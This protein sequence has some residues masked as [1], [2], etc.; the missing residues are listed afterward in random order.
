MRIGQPRLHM[1][2]MNELN[3][4]LQHSILTLAA[5]GWSNRRIARELGI[6]RETVSRH[7]RMADS[8]P[9]KVPPGLDGEL[10]PKPAKV[11]AG[12]SRIPAASVNPGESLLSRDVRLV[13][14]PNVFI[15]TWWLNVNL[16]AVTMR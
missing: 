13:C 16:P 6:H 4:S 14:Q 5:Q 12:I 2:A 8:K 15:R 10:E 1:S 3:V 11:P 9:A 7:L